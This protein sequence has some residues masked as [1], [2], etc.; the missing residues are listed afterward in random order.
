MVRC[1]QSQADSELKRS[2]FLVRCSFY[3]VYSFKGPFQITRLLSSFIC[4]LPLFYFVLEPEDIKIKKRP[5][6]TY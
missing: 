5:F 2:D 1:L 4:Y 3:N 6:L